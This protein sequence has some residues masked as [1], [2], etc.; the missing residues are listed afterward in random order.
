MAKITPDPLNLEFYFLR[1]ISIP[2]L[3]PFLILSKKFPFT[4]ST[5]KRTKG[6][7]NSLTRPDSIGSYRPLD[8]AQGQSGQGWR[9]LFGSCPGPQVHV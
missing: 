3:D 4:L 5:S 7:F 9:R 2:S 6:L 8:N 1:R